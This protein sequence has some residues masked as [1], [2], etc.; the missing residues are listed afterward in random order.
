M[1][2]ISKITIPSGD[3]YDL[4]DATARSHLVYY[5]PGGP[6]D[7]AGVWTGQCDQ[8][9]EYY[10]GLSV[11]YRPTIAGKSDGVT[12]NINDLGAVQC[13]MTHNGATT[14][15]TTH[16]PAFTPILFTY[17]GGKWF[18][19][20]YSIP[21]TNTT[22]ITN[23]HLGAGNYTMNSALYRFQLLFQMGE[24]T[25]TPLNNNSNTTGT[26]KTMLTSVEFDPFGQILYYNTTTTVA[27]GSNV[28]ANSLNWE[29]NAVDLRYTFNC[30]T[31]SYTA[32][33]YLYLVV[34]PQGNGKVKIASALPLTQTLP[35]T[36]DGYWYILL[37]RT[38]SAYQMSLYRH[39]P[40]YYHDGA[41]LHELHNIQ[42][43]TTLS[44][45]LMSVS[46]KN[47]LDG[48]DEGAQANDIKSISVNGTEIAPVGYNVDI[49]IPSYS[50]ATTSDSG[51]MSAADKAKLD[52]IA[53][54]ATANTGTITGI[55]MNGASKGT[56]GVVDLGTVIT[57]NPT[58]TGATTSANGTAGIVPTPS[59]DL[60]PAL[61]FLTA[62]GTWRGT[63]KATD[64]NVGS[65]LAIDYKSCCL[66]IIT[67]YGSTTE[68]SVSI[69][70]A[71]GTNYHIGNLPTN[72][73]WG[74]L[75]NPCSFSISTSTIET[76]HYQLT[77]NNAIAASNRRI[78]V[79][80]TCF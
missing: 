11:I 43:A 78:M 35:S 63:W 65:T 54:N 47:K 42:E 3:T 12:L 76:N 39:H 22:N 34:S 26:G 67:A 58:M 19:A 40:V 29:H 56:S 37:G 20:D 18:H 24:N 7:T 33:R 69:I 71:F 45:G 64:V 15:V 38:Y 48:I 23:L 44:A 30:G 60:N 74:G 13:Y 49:T 2:E 70:P 73:S 79:F 5:I 21:N 72:N 57:S 55:T 1:S 68:K 6:L 32:H 27:A 10:D 77:V 14:A 51:L 16:Y 31:T 9:T 62:A 46:D 66:V 75:Y 52:G 59:S 25:L 8:I 50:N 4:K 61:L 17:A 28:A 53:N 36:N 41:E 80:Y